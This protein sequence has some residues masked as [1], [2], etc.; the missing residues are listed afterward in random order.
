MTFTVVWKKTA[1]DALAELWI[2]HEHYRD[3]LSDAA[4]QIDALLRVDPQERGSPYIIPSRVL[5]VPPLGVIFRVIES[6]RLVRI[7]Q[8]WYVPLYTTNG[9]K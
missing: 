9:F 7:L 6:D 1:E 8:V 4:N 5:L 3:A 2:R